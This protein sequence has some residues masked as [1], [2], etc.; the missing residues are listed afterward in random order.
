MVP[1]LIAMNNYFHDVATAFLLSSAIVVFIFVK[2]VERDGRREVIDF[3]KNNHK[4]F[5]RI[6]RFSILW[7]VL[8]GIPRIIFFMRYEWLPAA[9]KGLIPAII[10]KHIL[11]FTLIVLGIFTWRNLFR[12]IDNIIKKQI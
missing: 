7:I 4:R 3:F 5:V 10:V 6:I 8:A 11:I 2:S 1:I 12:R 9:G